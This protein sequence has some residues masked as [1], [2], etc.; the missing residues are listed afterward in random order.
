MWIGRLDPEKNLERIRNEGGKIN[1]HIPELAQ[2]I[3][4]VDAEFEAKALEQDEEFPFILIAGR[5]MDMNA[6][7]LM[8]NPAWNKDRRACTLAVHPQDA[9]R[10][11]LAD[12]Q[13]AK[14]ITAAGQVD[15]E[16]QVTNATRPGQVIIPHGFGL[17]YDGEVYGANVN[18]LTKSTHRDPVAGTPLH[19][20]VLC[21]VEAA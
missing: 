14:V 9:G 16:L 7:T 18:R 2:E 3:Q 8:R 15:I 20:Y 6:N 12:A 1:V 5:H 10:L 11:K 13:M 19:R 17:Q 4:S 21:R